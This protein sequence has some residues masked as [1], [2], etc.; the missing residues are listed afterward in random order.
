MEVKGKQE[1][2]TGLNACE[3]VAKIIAGDSEAEAALVQQYSRGLSVILHQAT[4][5]SA[6][7]EDLFQDTF[8]I[9]LEKIRRGEVRDP[10]K[11]SGFICSLARNLALLHFRRFPRSTTFKEADAKEIRSSSP[12]QLDELLNR[13]KVRAIRQVL[14]ELGS[15]RDREILYRF[16]ISEEKKDQICADLELDSL[17]FNRVL[18][19]ARE[20]YRVLYQQCQEKLRGSGMG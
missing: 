10:E 20:R 16:Y 3:L 11:L 14:S 2:F 7:A 6:V 9:A 17:Q 18:H 13:E 15:Q 8:R 4:G 5:D 1:T 12:N 19:R